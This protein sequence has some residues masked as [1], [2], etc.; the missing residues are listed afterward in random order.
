[1]LR[2]LMYELYSNIR[3]VIGSGAVIVLYMA[4]LVMLLRDPGRRR[5]DIPLILSP[6]AAVGVSASR[7]FGIIKERMKE[8]FVKYA[9]VAFAA[10]LTVLAITSSGTFIFSRELSETAE[11]DMHIPADI[12]AA[13]SDILADGDTPVVLTMPG[14]DAYFECY[15]SAFVLPCRAISGDETA[16]TDEDD[17]TLLAELSKNSPD[18]KKVARIAHKKGCK[19]VVL[20]ADLWPDIAITEFGYEKMSETG[21]C[22]VYREVET[23]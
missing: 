12:M 17:R 8:P 20:A 16:I 7:I 19:Y 13:I 18:M 10:C 23:F 4:S 5:E 22:T 14:W 6:L 2:E 15:S 3:L 9:A 1:M 21:E 11:N